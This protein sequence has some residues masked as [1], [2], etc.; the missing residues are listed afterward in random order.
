MTSPSCTPIK[1]LSSQQEY[2]CHANVS[3][4]TPN[5]P[6]QFINTYQSQQ[7]PP[8]LFCGNLS[9]FSSSSFPRQ[10]QPPITV[11]KRRIHFLESPPTTTTTTTNLQNHHRHPSVKTDND[12]SSF[13]NEEFFQRM[14]NFLSKKQRTSD[15]A[16]QTDDIAQSATINNTGNSQ[17]P[18]FTP[19]ANQ[20]PSKR[21]KRESLTPSA[22]TT[23][24]DC[25]Q[26]KKRVKAFR[27]RARVRNE[28][29]AFKILRSQLPPMG[30]NQS[31]GSPLYAKTYL[32][33]VST[34]IEYIH[35]LNDILKESDEGQ[36]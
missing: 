25:K 2:Y 1:M 27:E 10:Q 14:L 13:M 22:T 19:Y 20:P 11:A 30:K 23:N 17:P 36:E 21:P 6:I 34:A 33:I 32:E 26:E 28:A 31:T 29:N 24:R 4:T 35:E 7:S 9:Q 16:T 15:S 3:P 18:V 5:T 8:D 12:N